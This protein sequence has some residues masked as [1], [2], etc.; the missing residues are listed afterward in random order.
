MELPAFHYHRP[1]SLDEASALLARHQGDVDLVA[2]GTDLLP[3][4][5]NRL[6][7]RSHVI[8][9]GGI[10][11]LQ[12]I[13]TRRIGAMARLVEIERSPLLQTRLPV[14]AETAS[15]ISSPPLRQHGTLGGNLML[16]TRCYYF[17]QS[18]L[19]RQSVD[20]CLKAEGTK[21]LVVPSSKGR[22]FAT[23]SG[24]MA[25]SL[26]ILGAKVELLSAAGARTLPL[27][28][29]FD[30][31]GI[32]RFRDRKEDELVVAVHIPE[33]AEQLSCG[34]RKLAIRDS[35]DFPSL[36]LALGLR[37]NKRG[38][39][40]DLRLATTA[41]ASRP[42]LLDEPMAE[43]IGQQASAQLAFRIGEVVQK[44]SVAYRNVPLDPKYRRKM[45]AVFTRRLLEAISP[46]FAN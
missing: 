44:A 19:W 29:F 15:K 13:S 18:P 46:A 30:E 21:C 5:K 33:E 20:F 40:E 41:M 6:N 23:Y 27:A 14:L 32:V 31:D 36:G 28:E 3:N 12:G 34:Y 2:G 8:S 26:L 39:I 22:C 10:S 17:N 1:N 25:A 45:V 43:F 35:I 42:E 37:I 11:A 4:Y 24:E 7:A 16:D 38:V 9:L